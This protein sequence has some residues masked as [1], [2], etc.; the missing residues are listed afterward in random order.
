[1]ILGKSPLWAPMGSVLASGLIVSMVLT[2]F[3]IPLLYFLFVSPEL[4][5]QPV[6]DAEIPIQYKP[7]HEG[8]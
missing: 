5:E 2:L 8:H 4:E 7:A 3:V 6:A 1:M